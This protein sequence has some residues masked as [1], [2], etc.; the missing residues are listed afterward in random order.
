M[1]RFLITGGAGFIGSN[2]VEHLIEKGFE[3]RVLDNVSTGNSDNLTEFQDR[4]D[5]FKGDIKSLEDV[6]KACE[7]VDGVFHQAALP[8]VTRSVKAPLETNEN[9]VVGSLNVLEACR[10]NDVKRVVYASSSSVYGD[11][12]E[13]PKKES[14]PPKPL[15]PYAASKIAMEYYFSAFNK[16]YGIDS[17]GLRYFNVYGKR[18]RPESE[19]AAVIP[20]FIHSVLCGLTPVIYGDGKQTRDF[21][22]IKDVVQANLLAMQSKSK[23]SDVF[24]VGG[25]KSISVNELLETISNLIGKDCK[26]Q[27]LPPREGDIRDSLADIT[28]IRETLLFSPEYDI[29]RGLRETIEWFKERD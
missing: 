25:G 11:T 19:Y 7:S 15:S 8:S 4:I 14:M 17:I 27:H 21:T 9:N 16:V 3:V 18:Q 10:K 28:K 20:K 23:G 13:L 29:E 24:N 26:A 1:E 2:L 6:V 22:Y 5:F 12:V